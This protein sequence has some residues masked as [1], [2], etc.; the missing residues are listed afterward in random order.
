MAHAILHLLPLTM[1]KKQ[2][3][4][5]NALPKEP[6]AARRPAPISI[7]AEAALSFLKDTKGAVTWTVLEL[8]GT[9]KITRADADRV[10]ALLQ[11]Q[12]YIQP[13]HANGEWM[14]TPSGET[15]SGAKLPRFDRDSVKSALAALQERIKQVNKDSKAA[16][17]TTAAVAFGDFLMKD[18]TRVQAADVGVQLSRRGD[19]TSDLQS[20]SGAH[21]ERAFL[22]QLRG[23]TAL[24]VLRPYEDWMK[25][26]S[27]L[28][29]M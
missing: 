29:L 5:T 21:E 18:R 1:P 27:N 19:R 8:A 28:N 23:R 6:A 4:A 2:V 24:L 15:V 26:R 25:S 14:T 20:A 16:F 7:P 22:R 17:K 12:G 11:A 3:R 13:A 10:V 9:L